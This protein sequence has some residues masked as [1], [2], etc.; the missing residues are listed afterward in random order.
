MLT[1]AAGSRP[2]RFVKDRHGKLALDPPH[3]EPPLHFN[4][5]HSDGIVACA[6]A[7]GISVGIDLEAIDREYDFADVL[8]STLAPEE[9]KRFDERSAAT[10]A[11]YFF[12]IWTLKEAIGKACGTG[13]GMPF[14]STCIDLEP[15]PRLVRCAPEIPGDG[16]HLSL[17]APLPTHQIA[18]AFRPPADRAPAVAVREIAA[19]DLFTES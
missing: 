2:W 9:R 13:L 8:D 17:H 16:W 11:D 3:G 6:T 12:A 5:T 19:A 15:A 10:R 7:R 18:L 14:Q 4:I 1:E